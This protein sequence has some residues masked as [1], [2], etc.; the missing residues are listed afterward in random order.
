MHRSPNIVLIGM[1]GVGK[2]TV[3]VL[4]A[5]RLGMDFVDTDIHIQSREGDSL[6]GLIKRLGSEGFCDLEARHIQNLSLRGHV[7]ATGGSVVYRQAAMRCLGADGLLLHLDIG[8]A[9]LSR[10]LDDIEARG[11][12]LTAGQSIGDLYLER[13]PLYSHYADVEIATDGLTPDQVV[14]CILKSL[15]QRPR[16]TASAGRA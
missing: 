13:R 14:A 16:R 4:L 3:G 6:Q 2:S 5:K 1:P 12:V 8:L 7:I 10:R 15:E 11:V 9:S